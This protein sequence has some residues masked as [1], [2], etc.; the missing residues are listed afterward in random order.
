MSYYWNHE[1]EISAD[2]ERRRKKVE[3]LKASTPTPP[4][5]EKLRALKRSQAE[6]A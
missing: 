2:L 1:D 3:A 6:A 5:V 4:I